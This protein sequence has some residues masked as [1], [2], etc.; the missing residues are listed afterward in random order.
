[1]KKVKDF[2]WYSVFMVY[3]F[4]LRD[5]SSSAMVLH[6]LLRSWMLWVW[7]IIIFVLRD[8]SSSAMVLHGL[9]RSWMLWVWF[10]IAVVIVSLC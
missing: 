9:L 7:F 8:E 3:I 1:M 10:I 5:E 6:G 2:L 4:V